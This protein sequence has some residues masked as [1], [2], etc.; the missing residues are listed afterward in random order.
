ML[1]PDPSAG[2]PSLPGIAVP[3]SRRGHLFH[4][5]AGLTLV[6][7][8]AVIAIIGVL[9]SLLFVGVGRMTARARE[10]K[11]VSNLR[12]VY[13]AFQ[14]YGQDNNQEIRPGFIAEGYPHA[15]NGQAGHFSMDI[16]RYFE[17]NI[18]HDRQATYLVCPEHEDELRAA[19]DAGS[20]SAMVLGSYKM[21]VKC[22]AT[23]TQA[24]KRW[25]HFTFRFAGQD[26][27][28]NPAHMLFLYDS[29]GPGHSGDPAT[30]I[31][32][33]RSGAHYLF[34]DGHVEWRK[35]PDPADTGMWIGE[36]S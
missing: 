10:V 16:S 1:S 28:P 32:R 6:E 34:L 19:Y 36:R 5:S 26:R 30:V 9:A 17:T 14:L 11:C 24:P 20:V 8:L 27:T 21:N 15:R 12:H 4:R 13:I 29:N 31:P 22:S 25:N 18:R 23:G 2:A 7:L 35:A 3:E 33:H